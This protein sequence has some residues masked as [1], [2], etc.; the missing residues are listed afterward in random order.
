MPGGV[1]TKND[2]ANQAL[3]FGQMRFLDEVII[4][5]VFVL[6]D[7]SKLFLW[8]KN[9]ATKEPSALIQIPAN[10]FTQLA[11]FAG[12]GGD[13]FVIGGVG[14]VNRAR[15]IGIEYDADADL[16]VVFLRESA[17][18]NGAEKE[19]EGDAAHDVL[20]GAGT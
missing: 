9:L 5:V 14:F 8:P 2:P 19:S 10:F 20:M 4:G 11:I 13:G 3:V 16:A 18:G 17:E 15:A 7:K 6:Q 12:G 1:V